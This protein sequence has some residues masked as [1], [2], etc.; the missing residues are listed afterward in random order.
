MCTQIEVVADPAASSESAVAS[1]EPSS[2]LGYQCCFRFRMMHAGCRMP[3]CLS[4]GYWQVC[5]DWVRLGSSGTPQKPVEHQI[6]S[7]GLAKIFVFVSDLPMYPLLIWL[8]EMI[9]IGSRVHAFVAK[10]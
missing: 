5:H 8:G 10:Y 4:S 1:S 9:T 2:G 6:F 7:D 3:L